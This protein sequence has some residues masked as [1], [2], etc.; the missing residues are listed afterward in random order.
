MPYAMSPGHTPQHQ[1]T[2]LKILIQ[3][4]NALNNCKDCKVYAPIDW[5]I[6][7]D[8]IVQP[9]VLIV[10]KPIQKKFLDFKPALVVEI[11]SPS[12]ASKD[13]G[14]KMELYQSQQVKYY[15]IVDAKFMKI[16]IYQFVEGEYDLVAI[17]LLNFLFIFEETNCKADVNFLSIWD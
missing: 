8:T 9:D 5:K 4:E 12:T 14:E 11:L 7:E 6:E 3:F 15:L 17:S 2:S 1:R 10:C 16:E 13:R